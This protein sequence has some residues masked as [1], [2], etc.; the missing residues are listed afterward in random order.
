M[1]HIVFEQ[2]PG[3]RA[4][5]PNFTMPKPIGRMMIGMALLAVL[6]AAGARAFNLTAR[7]DDLAPVVGQRALVLRDIN[8]GGVQVLDARTGGSLVVIANEDSARFLRTMLRGLAPHTQQRDQSLD[9]RFTLAMRE[10]GQLTVSREGSSRINS[11]NGFGL[12][13]V[14][15]LQ[16]LLIAR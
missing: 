1:S 8:G 6:V 15:S 10:N 9:V 12:S 5:A 16:R 14:A 11:V 4:D 7:T 13:Q 2:E 3:A